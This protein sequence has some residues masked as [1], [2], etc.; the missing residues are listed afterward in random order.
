MKKLF[1]FLLIFPALVLAQSTNQNFVKTTVYKV[2][3]TSPIASPAVAEATVAV[4]Y[5]DGLGRPIQKLA[6]GQSMSGNDIIVPIV[7]DALGRMPKDYLPLVSRSNSM[8]YMSNED[9]ISQLITDYG[10]QYGADGN[11]PYTEK[12]FENSPF[13]RVL[14]QAAPGDDWAIGNGHTIKYEYGLNALSDNIKLYTATAS[15][16]TTFHLYDV[17]IGNAT[18][19]TLYPVEKLYKTVMKNENWVSGHSNTTEEYKNTEGQVLLKRSFNGNDDPYDTY[20]VYDQFGNLS[21]VIPPAIIGDTSGMLDALCYQYRYDDKNRL[22]EKKLPGKQ[23]E[24][25]VY[26][27]LNRV[28]ATG[29]AL[30]PFGTGVYGWL[31]SKYDVF[32]RN[33]L[34]A[35]VMDRDGAVDQDARTKL[36]DDLNGTTYALNETKSVTDTTINGVSFRYNTLTFPTLDYHVLT[37]NYFDDYNYPDAPT[38]FGTVEGQ[39]VFYNNSTQKPKGFP[40]GSW[41]RVLQTATDYIGETTYSFYDNKARV[42]RTKTK[43]YLSGYSQTDSYYDF[44]G[45]VTYTINRHKRDAASGTTEIYVKDLYSYYDNDKLKQHQHQI[46]VS[47]YVEDMDISEY[48]ELGR[49]TT[50]AV[51][52]LQTVDYRYNIRGWLTGIN[53]VTDLENDLFAFKINYNQTDDAIEGVDKLY[54]GN[55]AETF[56]ITA[57]DNVL[58]MYGYA[59]DDLNR[60]KSATYLKHIEEENNPVLHSYD[61]TMRYDRNGNIHDLQRNGEYDDNVFALQIDNLAY[62]YDPLSPNRL[63]RVTDDTN[64]PNG[65]DDDSDAN[66]ADDTDDYSY[67][68]NGNLKKD[69]NKGIT[70]ITY[71]HLNLPVRIQFG[72]L[73]K[74]EYLYNAAGQK[75]RKKVSSTTAPI[76]GTTTVRTTD[77]LNGFQYFEGKLEFFAT[78]EGYVKNTED[79]NGHHF[80]YVYNY[81]DHLGNVRLSYGYDPIDEVVKIL[82]ENNYYAYG[83]KHNNYNMSQSQYEKIENTVGIRDAAN[84]KSDGDFD[85]KYNGKEWQD[86]FGLNMYDMDFRDYDPSIGRWV[87]IDPIDH[88]GQSPYNGYDSNPVFWA[89]PSGGNVTRESG[90]DGQ[91]RN[92]FD[93]FGIYIPPMDRTE[94]RQY[95]FFDVL[96]GGNGFGTGGRY[97]NGMEGF[98]YKGTS[99]GSWYRYYIGNDPTAVPEDGI[100]VSVVAMYEYEFVENDF[101]PDPKSFKFKNFKGG[102]QESVVTGL[103]FWVA[104]GKLG[105]DGVIIEYKY[106][107]Y[108]P[109]PIK[110]TVPIGLKV[111]DTKITN[112]VAAAATAGIVNRIMDRTCHL[113]AGTTE[114]PMQV[115][116]YFRAQLK[117]EY[118]MS[119]PGARLN[120]NSMNYNVIPT[121]FKHK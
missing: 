85:Y 23:W 4:T 38:T 19:T 48:D 101:Y 18:G 28:V 95:N 32:N 113:F 84:G 120:F 67:D 80:N 108:F 106:F 92:K 56:W 11:N 9:A 96:S 16:N 59:Y 79:E 31:A 68:D 116:Q 50:K 89:D 44:S 49:L 53:D 35:W 14:E 17:T 83:L 64:N 58:R 102:W 71:N 91:G 54:N 119:I 98:L 114:S 94:G 97:R 93:E 5:F 51:G 65:F 27:K 87:V 15:W 30:S 42:L 112:E 78:S 76:G 34:T 110:F 25:I 29:P 41:V 100:G 2:P 61:E 99:F 24:F 22:V 26:D 63:M 36:Q 45:K 13:S 43:N 33:V 104:L 82:E 47:G 74:I 10:A 88:F 62:A 111:G 37:V 39:T 70:T 72:N 121:I 107:M 66:V 57:N 55:I 109:Q 40:T 90:I 46:G 75:V 118:E 105:P 86:E 73:R 12:T 21:L 81:T 6:A 77:Y 7:Y 3:T 115:E 20:Y 60:L 8:D 52:G 103:Y 117:N 69:Q 1:Y